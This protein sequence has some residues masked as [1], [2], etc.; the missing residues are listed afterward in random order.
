M[1]VLRGGVVERCGLTS[2][3]GKGLDFLRG[4]ASMGG[5]R[6]QHTRIT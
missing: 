6:W 5:C 3:G 2:E 4:G 1:P